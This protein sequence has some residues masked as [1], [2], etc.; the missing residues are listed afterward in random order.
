[1]EHEVTSAQVLHHEEE[2]ALEEARGRRDD[3]VRGREGSTS[4]HNAAA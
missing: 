4:E 2:M 1:M 3:E